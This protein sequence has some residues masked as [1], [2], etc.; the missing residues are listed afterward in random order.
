METNGSSPK[1]LPRD[2]QTALQEHDAVL[3]LSY[4]E[5]V[6]GV[7]RLL[8][9]DIPKEVIS[10]VVTQAV[11]A[12]AKDFNPLASQEFYARIETQPDAFTAEEASLH[13]PPDTTSPPAR[14]AFAVEEPAL[15]A[16]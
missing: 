12:V 5:I 16:A 10:Q 13:E 3:R 8:R 9:L 15:T 2:I 14:T 11:E 6:S 7:N 4:I 1:N